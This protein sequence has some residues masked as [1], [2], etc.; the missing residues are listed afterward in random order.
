[1]TDPIPIQHSW[2]LAAKNQAL[3]SSPSNDKQ[4]T[5]QQAATTATGKEFLFQPLSQNSQTIEPSHSA[6]KTVEWICYCQLMCIWYKGTTG[7]PFLSRVRGSPKRRMFTAPGGGSD[8]EV[9]KTLLSAILSLR[10]SASLSTGHDIL[11]QL[12]VQSF[13]SK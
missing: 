11:S 1:M 8:T 9:L 13:S 4:E 5:M 3:G 6:L 7:S 2:Y 10:I 12:P